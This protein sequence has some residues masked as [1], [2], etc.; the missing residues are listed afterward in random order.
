MNGI[1]E[2]LRARLDRQHGV[3][4][5]CQALDEG[6][7]VTQIRS[8]LGSGEWHEIHCGVYS[9]RWARPFWLGRLMAAVLASGGTA[10]HRSAARLHGLTRFGPSIEV[11]VGRDCAVELDGVVL[12]R[13]GRPAARSITTVDS[14]FVTTIARTVADL[15][16]DRGDI[17]EN[18][19]S[20]REGRAERERRA[21]RE[22]SGQKRK[23]MRR[24]L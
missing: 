18:P 20:E 15:N 13:I 4:S 2:G 14:I 21:Q 9:Y 1:P 23:I 8:G 6:L 22:G 7:T 19:H 3:V 24:T 11:T 10:S 5:R 16:A 17:D 12:H